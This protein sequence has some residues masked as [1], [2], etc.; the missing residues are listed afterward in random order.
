V[1]VLA[2]SYHYPLRLPSDRSGFFYH[3][4]G[5]VRRHK[6]SPSAKRF[7][8]KIWRGRKKVHRLFSLRQ[9]I[10]RQTAALLLTACVFS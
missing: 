9:L 8:G 2:R 4:I 3:R 5:F 6:K 7:T 1:K 10:H